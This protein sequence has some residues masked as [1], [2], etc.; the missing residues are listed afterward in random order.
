M[1]VWFDCFEMPPIEKWLDY[2]NL[3]LL[4]WIW[5]STSAQSFFY[6]SRAFALSQLSRISKSQKSL[7][8]NF[9][10]TFRSIILRR[11]LIFPS[12]KV[13]TSFKLFQISF[14]SPLQFLLHFP[15][16]KFKYSP[17]PSSKCRNKIIYAHKTPQT[18]TISVTQW[19]QN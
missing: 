7:C 8:G 16:L 12:L 19:S 10:E 2:S 9:E 1:C 5:A 18:V 6:S 13:P 3:M 11:I 14:R 15:A 17:K 4:H